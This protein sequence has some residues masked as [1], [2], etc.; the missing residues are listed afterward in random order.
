MLP[1][2]G[3]LVDEEGLPLTVR[4]VYLIDSDKKIRLIQV[5]PSSTG[6]D[7]K[8]II[9]CIDSIKLASKHPVGK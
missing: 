2:G 8:E 3:K 1:T 4:A 6:R 5:Y 7:W 9:R